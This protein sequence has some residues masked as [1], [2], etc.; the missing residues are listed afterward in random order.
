[1]HDTVLDPADDEPETP[2][3]EAGLDFEADEVQVREEAETDGPMEDE[4]RDDEASRIGNADLDNAIDEFVDLLNARDYEGL[5]DLL[6]SDVEAEF[7]GGRSRDEVLDGW[8]DLILRYPT[9]LTTRA[10]LGSDPIVAIWTFDDEADRFDQF[11]FLLFE[12]DETS[13]GLVQRI[14][15]AEEIAD[16]DELVIETPERS[17]LP[18]WE[19]WS[20]LDEG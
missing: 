16:S 8:N 18:E 12:M 5:G 7:L 10:D 17:D 4:Y 14:S 13:E 15:Y 11:G 19:E 1:M 3:S 9:L 20:E 2:E 6:A